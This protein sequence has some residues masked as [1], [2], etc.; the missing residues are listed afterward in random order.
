MLSAL[1]VHSKHTKSYAKFISKKYRE[2]KF[3]EISFCT[4]DVLA[5]KNNKEI[6]I[7]IGGGQVIDTAKIISK[8][9]KCIAIPTTA[10][11]AAMT[12]HSVI[13][14]ERKVSISTEKPVLEMDFDMT[15]S[16]VDDVLQSTISDAL[17]HAVESLWSKNSTSQSKKYSIKAISLIEEYFENESIHTLIEAGNIAGQAIEL[18][19]TN[20]IHA[21]SYPITIKYGVKH[22]MACGMNLISFMKY[23][24]SKLPKSILSNLKKFN[25]P[26]IETFDISMIVEEAM[27]HDQFNNCSKNISKKDLSLIIKEKQND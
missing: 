10:S 8:D 16:L 15:I 24:D 5:I 21:T 22:G 6:V 27:G 9:K 1:I 19:G 4:E 2:V 12:S 20:V 23:M 13:W 25:F 11:G 26:K 17:S 3:L 18:V 14:G 7:G